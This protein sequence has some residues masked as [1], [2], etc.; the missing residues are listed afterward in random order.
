M[1]SQ[2]KQLSLPLACDENF[3][4][5]HMEKRTGCPVS[6]TITDNTSSMV[7]VGRKDKAIVVRLHRMFLL[8]GP[9]VLEE[10][11]RFIRKRRGE[12]P[13]LRKFV[14]D[15]SAAIRKRSPRRTA[16]RTRGRHHDLRKIYDS[17]NAEYFDGRMTSLITWGAR[18]GGYAVRKRTL[19]SYARHTHTVRINPVLD[20]KTVP[21]YF[22][23][24]VVYHEMLHADIGIS[25]K[26][27]RRSIHS[28]EFRRRE[29]CFLHYEKAMSWERRCI[30]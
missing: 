18:C 17:I 28:R 2:N 26:D 25:E 12:T 22:I 4:R 27:G 8:A 19:G 11:A 29:K 1:D 3:L 13:L 7:S 15:N 23:E 5:T 20:K 6:L 9:D 10:L 16:L 30:S 14:K 24:F 21:R